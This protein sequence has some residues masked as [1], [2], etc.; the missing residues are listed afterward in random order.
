ML[1]AFLL[2]VIDYG[3][4]LPI[5]ILILAWLVH[6][7]TSFRWRPFAVFAG[8]FGFYLLSLLFS[9]DRLNGLDDLV[10]K[11]SLAL[12]P[13]VFAS[14][15]PTESRTLRLVL[16]FFVMGTVVALL[17]AFSTS[18]VEYLGTGDIHTFYMS[19][20]SPVHHPSYL[21]MFINFSIAVLLLEIDREPRFQRSELRLWTVILVL[22]LSLIFPAAK[23]GLITFGFLILFFVTRRV[24]QGRFLHLRTGLLLS[25]AAMFVVFL[26]LDPLTMGRLETAAEVVEGSEVGR[27]QPTIESTTARLHIWQVAADVIRE[28]PWGL[29]AGDVKPALNEAYEERG[30]TALARQGLNAHNQFLQVALAVGIPGFLWFVFTLLYPVRRLWRRRDWIYGFFLLCIAA[31]LAVESMLEKQSGILFYSFFN[32]LLFFSASAHSSTDSSPD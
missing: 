22:A 30:L 23:M 15:R 31:N 10:Q 14:I 6:P 17:I 19:R 5:I 18:V 12:F 1:F 11:I 20:F 21:A 24:V 28:H 8:L 29:G 3:I 27:N 9:D 26:S 7:K 16:R 4:Q 32:A 13:L 2:P 25:V